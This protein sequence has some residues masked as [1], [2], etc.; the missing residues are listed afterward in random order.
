MVNRF[1][2]VKKKYKKD[3]LLSINFDKECK[4]VFKGCSDNYYS[5]LTHYFDIEG[6]K[7]GGFRFVRRFIESEKFN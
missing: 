2:H 7:L 6:G 1:K 3:M 4:K 5:F